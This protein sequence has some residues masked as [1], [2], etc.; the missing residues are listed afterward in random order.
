MKSWEDEEE[1]DYRMVMISMQ[2]MER[3][4]KKLN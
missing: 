3:N 2:R 4:F 1:E